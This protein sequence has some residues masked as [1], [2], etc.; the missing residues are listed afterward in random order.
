VLLYAWLAA[1]TALPAALDPLSPSQRAVR[2]SEEATYVHVLQA[3]RNT[4]GLVYA[5]DVSLLMAA[6]REVAA[7]AFPVTVLALDGTWDE[8]PFVEMIRQHRFAA[9][10][11]GNLY[12]PDRFTPRVRA[13]ILDAYAPHEIIGSHYTFYRPR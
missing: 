7:E 6:N 13:A 3:V 9:L 12:A 11:L 8:T 2:R 4:P 10:V 5:E 1:A